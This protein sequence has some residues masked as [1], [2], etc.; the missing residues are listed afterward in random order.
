MASAGFQ[1]G[2]REAQQ[3]CYFNWE[4]FV[5]TKSKTQ[6]PGGG[7]GHWRLSKSDRATNKHAH[8]HKHQPLH[9]SSVVTSCHP[10]KT[11]PPLARDPPQSLHP[12]FC[13]HTEAMDH[14]FI[15]NT[16]HCHVRSFPQC[17][18]GPLQLSP[19]PMLLRT[20]SPF[21]HRQW[22]LLS[23]Y[24]NVHELLLNGTEW[25]ECVQKQVTL[26]VCKLFCDQGPL[27]L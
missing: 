8:T 26:T 27:L 11:E 20:V 13:L 21:P 25:T 5:G 1:R 10:W 23:S 6:T 18:T 16:T 9:Y 15:W 19:W 2:K 3:Y 7:L 22:Q 14:G 12:A 4:E 24:S 17:T